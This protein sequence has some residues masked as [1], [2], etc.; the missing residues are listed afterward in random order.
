MSKLSYQMS[1]DLCTT[2]VH[3]HTDDNTL[4]LYIYSKQIDADFIYLTREDAHLRCLY[5]NKIWLLPFSLVF[6]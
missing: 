6:V 5:Y 1:E 3:I 2:L 4:H